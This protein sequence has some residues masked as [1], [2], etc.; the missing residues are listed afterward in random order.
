MQARCALDLTTTHAPANR[1]GFP[2]A[3]VTRKS[4]T[5]IDREGPP[6]PARA[7]GAPT[8]PIYAE[9]RILCRYDGRLFGRHGDHSPTLLTPCQPTTFLLCNPGGY[10]LLAPLLREPKSVV[11]SLAPSLARLRLVPAS[12][13]IGDGTIMAIIMC[14]GT[15]WSAMMALSI[16]TSA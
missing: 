2:A 15:C 4:T 1:P 6:P 14:Q 16:S 11:L 3:H 8:C 12:D 13:L 5:E 7:Q 10:G 9:R